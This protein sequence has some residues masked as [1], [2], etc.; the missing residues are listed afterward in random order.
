LFKQ[1]PNEEVAFMEL[2]EDFAKPPK[3]PA[4]ACLPSAEKYDADYDPRNP[5]CIQH[6]PDDVIKAKQAELM[7]QQMSSLHSALTNRKDLAPEVSKH[8][9]EVLEDISKE[10][11]NSEPQE[12][13]VSLPSATSTKTPPSDSSAFGTIP[14]DEEGSNSGKKTRCRTSSLCGSD[15]FCIPDIPDEHKYGLDQYAS[16][17]ELGLEK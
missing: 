7:L 1:W 9:E 6:V 17:E 11:R 3:V 2:P 14:G 12:D 13:E 4:V 15:G 10:Q 5:E 8:Y 16:A